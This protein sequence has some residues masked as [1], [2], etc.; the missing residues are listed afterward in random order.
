MQWKWKESKALGAVVALLA[1]F[2]A[3]VLYNVIVGIIV[4][5]LVAAGGCLGWYRQTHRAELDQRARDRP[6]PE[7]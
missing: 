2:V 1:G 4:F 6:F 5:I 7:T 3:T